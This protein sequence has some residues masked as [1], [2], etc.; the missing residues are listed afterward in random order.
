MFGSDRLPT[1]VLATLMVVAG[2]AVPGTAAE[3]GRGDFAAVAARARRL[4]RNGKAKPADRVAVLAELAEHA[5]PEAAALIATVGLAA[6]DLAARTAARATLV[7]LAAD[8]AVKAHLFAEYRR[9]SKR[10]GAVTAEVALVLL[11]VEADDE[12]G[13]FR[14][15]LERM[16]RAALLTWTAAVCDAASRACDATTLT[17]VR[18]LATLRCFSDSLP[19]RRGVIATLARIPEPQAIEALI[20]MLDGVRGEARG[21]VIRHLEAVSGERHGTDVQAWRNWFAAHRDTA[22]RAPPPESDPAAAEAPGPDSDGSQATYYD[23]PIHADRIVFVLDTSG[24]MGGPRLEAAKRELLS[25][26]FGLPDE[27]RFTVV[28]FNSDVGS[29]RGMLVQANDKNKRDAAT[30]VT[31]LTAGG[32]T[33]TSDALQAA[34]TFDAEA[35]FLLSDGEPSAGRIVEPAGIIQFVMRLNRGRAVTVNT[36]GIMTGE[37]FLDQLARANHGAFRAVAE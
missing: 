15:L 17:A 31:R 35:I 27:T 18:T 33:A 37:G 19:C 8:P 16:P 5:T 20:D 3:P 10:P 23:I 28:F 9:Q 30:F 11:A 1:F 21:D 32:G 24:S 36:I 25:A 22:G 34:F 13:E 29:W 26:I 2:D 14:G 6:A 7:E 12:H 4:A